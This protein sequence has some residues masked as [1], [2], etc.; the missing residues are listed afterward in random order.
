M[1]FGRAGDE[2]I[3]AGALVEVALSDIVLMPTDLDDLPVAFE[4]E[5]ELQAHAAFHPADG[6]VHA[7]RN[8]RRRYRLDFPWLLRALAQQLQSRRRPD[9]PAWSPVCS[10][11]SAKPGSAGGRGAFC[12]HAG[13]G[14][15]TGSIPS[16]TP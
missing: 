9:Q 2:L 10:G 4:W 11:I 6:W 13:S 8:T 1:H 5:P 16:A 7:D 14:R 3:A 12:S 15:S